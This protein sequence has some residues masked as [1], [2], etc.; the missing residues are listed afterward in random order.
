MIAIL[1]F[2]STGISPSFALKKL[3]EQQMSGV[4]GKEGI[5]IDIGLN[6]QIDKFRFDDD[7]AGGN[8]EN[9]VAEGIT[10][11]DGS[12]N[13][14]NLNGLTIDA[15]GSDGLVLGAPGGNF[16]A[17]VNNF[18]L[19]DISPSSASCDGS[20]SGADQSFG[21]I[22]AR[23]ISFDEGGNNSALQIKGTGDG[24]SGKV[25]A[26]FHINEFRYHDRNGEAGGQS[27]GSAGVLELNDVEIGD[28]GGNFAPTLDNN[29]QID[30]DG[31]DGF[32]IR[33]PSPGPP[34]NSNS[35][36][37]EVDDVYV[38]DPSSNPPATSLGKFW[39]E[40]FTTTAPGGGASN[41]SRFK[42]SPNGDG[43]TIEGQVFFDAHRIAWQNEN[44]NATA[45][46][47]AVGGN[48]EFRLHDGS[49]NPYTFD[50]FTVGFNSQD[51]I[52]VGLPDDKFTLDVPQLDLGNSSPGIG[53]FFNGQRFG[54][55]DEVKFRFIGRGEGI[56]AEIDLEFDL[57][58]LDLVDQD[59][60]NGTAGT[61]RFGLGSS[62]EIEFGSASNETDPAPFTNISIDADP[63][64]GLVIGLPDGSFQLQTNGIAV[65]TPGNFNNSMGKLQLKNADLGSGSEIALKG[66]G[67]GI[68]GELLIDNAS[69]DFA[70]LDDDGWSGGS[71]TSGGLYAD[72]VSMTLQ[73]ASGNSSPAEFNMNLDGSRGMVL[74][75][76]QA[77]LD[78]QMDTLY[79]GED[80]SP[81][82]PS[83]V[84]GNF[85]MDGTQVDVFSR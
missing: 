57:D 74:E 61:V 11:D 17:D 8:T 13:Q 71:A 75:A 33:P 76:N 51:W 32:V 82:T 66:Q 26:N 4:T 84:R 41:E 10:L 40:S 58:S 69:F 31:S 38:G 42:I 80:R 60:T 34:A 47:G 59:G 37:F 28:R 1:F 73:K 79:M 7:G 9:F 5:S 67:N 55:S 23:G 64:R 45:Q 27:S 35:L 16:T 36:D 18:C 63:S 50:N 83:E 24:L 78:F 54:F 20:L 19:D 52:E 14:A 62:N 44:A 85:R 2:V 3:S 70:I 77:H 21:R 56:D 48:G 29:L 15:D 39:I 12:G 43:V 65:G 6:A 81:G 72:N 22:E 53:V 30:L 49:N 68:D 46:L 25:T